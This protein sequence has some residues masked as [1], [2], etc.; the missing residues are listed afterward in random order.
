VR[1][2][3]EGGRARKKNGAGAPF[4]PSRRAARQ[5]RLRAPS[6]RARTPRAPGAARQA[7]CT[8]GHPH[9]KARRTGA[10]QEKGERRIT[11]P[12]LAARP[13][14]Q[15]LTPSAAPVS[16]SLFTPTGF[17][18]TRRTKIICTIGPASSDAKTLGE[19]AAAGMNVAR[20]N[21]C[22]GDH[23]WHKALIHRIRSL[24]KEKG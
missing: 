23:A 19:L 10:R 2:W 21:M 17:R 5:S 3:S 20:L 12:A 6:C 18:S 11:A 14:A 1:K 22:H 15:T 16:L 4:A 13:R 7:A 8:S 9:R 24:N